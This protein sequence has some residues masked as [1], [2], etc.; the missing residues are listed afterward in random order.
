ML[1]TVVALLALIALALP[2][3][4][5]TVEYELPTSIEVVPGKLSVTFADTVDAAS[6]RAFVEALGYRVEAVNFYDVVVSARADTT[7]A[8][9]A[10]ER[11]RADPRV[12]SVEQETLFAPDDAPDYL[13]AHYPAYTVTLGLA[14]SL[15]SEAARAFATEVPGLR[16]VRVRKLPNDLVVAVDDEAAALEALE[17]SPLVAYVTYLAY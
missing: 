10:V 11:L 17:A 5:Q 8:P 16:D 3:R 2:V 15:H 13:R 7:L 6:A 4:A 1:R 14:P 9:G 12:R